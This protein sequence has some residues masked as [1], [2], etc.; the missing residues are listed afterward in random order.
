VGLLKM[1][2]FRPFP[3][4]AMVNSLKGKKAIGVVDRSLNFGHKGGPFYTELKSFETQL[5]GSPMISFIDGIA[6]T[7][8]TTINVATM[9]D[10]ICDLAEGKEVREVTWVS[11]PEANEPDLEKTGGQ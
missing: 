3:G 4:E 5:E 7:D 1:R 11:Y 9:I 10:T 2:M 8:I 6:N